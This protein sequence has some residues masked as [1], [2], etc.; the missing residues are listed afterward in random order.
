MLQSIKTCGWIPVHFAWWRFCALIA[1]SIMHNLPRHSDFISQ[2]AGVFDFRMVL[3]IIEMCNFYDPSY[4]TLQYQ[5][6]RL[7]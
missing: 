7:P 2:I 5:I 1:G 3:N 6:K 4:A